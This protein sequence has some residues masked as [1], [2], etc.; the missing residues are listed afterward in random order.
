MLSPLRLLAAF[1]LITP[2]VAG[3]FGC[4]DS[5]TIDAAKKGPGGGDGGS[6]NTDPL[7]TDDGPGICLL[8]NCQADAHCGACDQERTTCKLDEGR[9]VACNAGTATGCP[10]GEYCTSWGNCAPEGLECATDS[11]GTPQISCASNDGCLACDPAH[12]VCDPASGTC[13]ACTEGDTSECA[14]DD[15]C[16]AGKC[17]DK[18]PST[19]ETDND[20]G[21]CGQGQGAA[22]ACHAHKCAECSATY[23]CPAGLT[24]SANGTCEQ[25]CGDHGTGECQSDA[26]CAGCGTDNSGLVCHLPVNGGAGQCGPQA[27][28]CSDLG[29]GV[30]VLPAPYNQVTNLCSNDGD[31]NGVGAQLN[32]GKMLRD[33]TGI[34]GIDDANLN[35]PMNVCA[36]VSISN[37]SCGVCVPCQVDSDCEDIDIDQ[38]ALDAFGPIGSI[39]AAFLLDQ[40][41][42]AADHKIYMYCEAVAGD[43][44]ACVPCPGFMY[45]CSVGGGGGSGSGSCSHDICSSGGPLNNSCGACADTVCSIDSFCCDTEWD[46]LCVQQAEDWCGVSCGTGGGSGSCNHNECSTGSALSDGCS[47][48]VTDV[49]NADSFCCTDT[50]DDI[51]I[52]QAEYYCGLDCSGGGGGGACSHNECDTGAG[53][54]QTCSSCADTVCSA[55][56]YCCD[57]AWDAT[58]VMQAADWCGL[59][60]G[61]GNNSCAHDECD[62]GDGLYSECSNC[63]G[64]VCGSDPYCCDTAWDATCVGEAEDWCGIFCG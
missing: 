51:C 6:A 47:S 4:A 10:D 28:G 1:A 17:E 21:Q 49:C 29:N 63:A 54:V 53:L 44:G 18:C 7:G 23:A 15:V 56:S 46:S 41:F 48:C 14:S 62:T 25:E 50:W 52:E 22:R 64:I 45:D 11:H 37:V 20:C 36:D 39:A 5:D 13:V 43:Y 12:Q 61:T 60:C 32:V 35:Y 42:G 33:L 16:I 26:D 9:C 31:C 58:C 30:A 24:C 8:H 57:T 38:L 55:D 27:N 2:L 59:S 3:T 34:E 19:C 40:V